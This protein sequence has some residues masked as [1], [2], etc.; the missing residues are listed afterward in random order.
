MPTKAQEEF[1]EGFS[2]ALLTQK[3]PNRY[4]LIS[5]IVNCWGKH[6]LSLSVNILLRIACHYINHRTIE[7]FRLEG[8][9]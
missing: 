8:T 4:G 2:K 3:K 1:T 6:F 7:W 5:L 9:L